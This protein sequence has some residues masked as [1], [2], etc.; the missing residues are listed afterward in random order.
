MQQ[1]HDLFPDIHSSWLSFPFEYFR[2]QFPSCKSFFHS[3]IAILPSAYNIFPDPSLSPFFH[4]PVNTLPFGMK[5]LLHR[6]VFHFSILQY[7]PIPLRKRIFLSILLDYFWIL[8]HKIFW[9]IRIL[10]YSLS[11]SIF[12]VSII[13]HPILAA[14]SAFSVPQSAFPLTIV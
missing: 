4:V 8:P 14:K 6:L 5:F 7:T 3:P 9:Q 2:I 13:F 1:L 11:K 10:A 12:P